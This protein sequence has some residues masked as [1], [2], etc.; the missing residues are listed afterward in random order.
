[1]WIQRLRGDFNLALIVMFG[2]ITALGITPFAIYRFVNG[3]PLIGTIDLVLVGVIAFGSIQSWRSGRT[4]GWAFFNAI[5]YSIGCVAIAH[6]GGLSGLFWV[7]AVVVANFLLV[8]RWRAVLLS[9]GAIVAITLTD[10]TLSTFAEK[11]MF[12]STA[13]IVS[14]FAYV[15]AWRSEMQHLELE[16]IALR[17]PLTG[18]SN[19]R[20]MPAELDIAMANSIRQGKPLGLLVFDLDHFKRINDSFGHEAGDD[21]LVQVSNLVNRLTRKGDRFFRLGGEEFGLLV[22]G[23]DA[24]ALHEIAEKLR[25]SVEREIQCHQRVVT[26]SVGAAVFR[27]GETVS[28][29]QARA[30]AA[31][32]RAKRSGR[33]RSVIDAS[34]DDDDND[35]PPDTNSR[36]AA[37]LLAARKTPVSPMMADRRSRDVVPRPASR[38]VA[39]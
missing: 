30:D 14:L 25:T 11:T 6:L 8:R 4:E 21:V 13:F 26:M 34:S 1:M 37:A 29:W 5:T 39:N 16:A 33:N 28:D 36:V 22:P 9:A 17:D 10:A 19:R 15:F 7:Y 2:V 38:S 3:Q 27:A 24:A 18:A 23:A 12:V 31:M 32:Y 20:G 35:T